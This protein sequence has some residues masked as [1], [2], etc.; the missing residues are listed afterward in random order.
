MMALMRRGANCSVNGEW[1]Q[2]VS[3]E[4]PRLDGTVAPQGPVAALYT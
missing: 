4:R 1:A 2:S 3:Q